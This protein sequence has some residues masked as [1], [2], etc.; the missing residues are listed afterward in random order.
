MEIE[1]SVIIPVYNVEKYLRQCLDSVLNQTF[2]DKIEVILVNDGSTDSS[3][4]I[5]C[6]YKK[7]F[8][9]IIR[10]ISQKNSG[11]SATRNAALNIAQGKFLVFIDSDDYIGP[12]HLEDL[13]KKATE[14][15]ADMVICDYTRVTAEGE[16]YKKFLANHVE[17]GIRI[18]SYISCNRIVK[19]AL[20]EEYQIRYKE[21][22][23]CED[24]PVM[25]KLEAVAKRIE[26]ISS[27]EYY[28]RMNPK[29][30]TSTFSKKKLR[31]EQLP[32]DALKESVEFC[33]NKEHMLEYEKLEFFICRI[34]TTLIFD[35]G[36]RCEKEIRRAMCKEVVDFMD[37]YFPKSHKNKYVKLNYFSKI[38]KV[39]KWGTW[40]FVKALRYRMLYVLSSIC[41]KV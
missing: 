4:K 33:M 18:P 14:T 21:G 19:R 23:I 34:W 17:N 22:I 37:Y 6:E 32:F 15:E 3:E 5:M 13:H 40:L 8:P 7:K 30:I 12:N 16:F 38:P 20:F 9:E 39:H 28:Y 24:I 1:I 36:R 25:L 27:A 41:S 29:S 2:K 31:M 10:M 26:I 35:I 11:L